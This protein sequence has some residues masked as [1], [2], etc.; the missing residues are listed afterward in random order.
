MTGRLAA[1]GTGNAIEVKDLV[2]TY[3]N[4]VRALNGLT[5]S[6]RSGSI[7]A[8]LGPNGAGKST[9][10][11]ILTTLSMPDSGQASVAGYDVTRDPQRVRRA[12]GCVAQRSGV[13]RE[14]TGREN[15][16]LQGQFHGMRSSEIK[17]RVGEL[18]RQFSLAE[19]GDRLA[20]TYSGGMQRK[21]DIAMAL[22]HRPE[23]LFL[24]EPTTG[25]DPEARA[26]LWSEI[27]RLSKG[28]LT[29]LLT[30]HY[31]EEADKLAEYVAIA[32]R[33]RV[34]AEG[35]PEDLKAELRGDSVHI[36]L[37]NPE[38]QDRIALALQDLQGV[39]DLQVHDTQIQARADHGGTAVPGMLLALQAN[40]IGVTSVRVSRPT[41]DDVYLKHTGR[42]LAEAEGVQ[43]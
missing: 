37:T 34:V 2:K 1:N 31:L 26:E 15:L 21:L 18:L 29:I 40:G 17:T 41:L 23:V 43:N 24:D 3:K 22:I 11:K 38:S 10:V 19:A 33:G 8:L 6:V 27:E 35:P 28:G 13:D 5:L 14:S 7:F 39:R 16:T 4:N 36:D 30:T 25:L 9:T 12:I 42:T 32:D 20:R